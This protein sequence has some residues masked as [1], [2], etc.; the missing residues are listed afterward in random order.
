M[1]VFTFTDEMA[2]FAA[3]C[4]AK[5]SIGETTT[6]F[7][8]K[9]GT[10]RTPQRLRS[11]IKSR[12]FRN[13]R[14]TG[15]IM[16]GVSKIFTPEQTQFFKDNYP[17]MSRKEL[18]AAFNENYGTTFKES[19]IVGFLKANKIKSG[20]TGY[21]SNGQKSWNKGTKGLM[22][23]NGGS[24]KKG[25]AAHNLKPTGSQRVNVE[26]YVE[27]KIDGCKAWKLKQRVVY[28]QHF[29]PLTPA[30]VV[31]FKDGNRLNVDPSN[32]EKITRAEHHY[33]N[34]LGHNTAPPEVKPVI[35]ALA[36]LQA[37]VADRKKA[38]HE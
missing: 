20:R 12:G 16:K 19:Q 10:D 13:G 37:K 11:N 2:D 14:T 35:H 34:Q 27:I 7:N 22:K 36:K 25:Q 4:Y 31:R 30:D 33:L 3:Q 24:F 1:A 5:M 21:Y 9:F 18:T 15:E 6:L 29:G 26:G 38:T 17:N 23:P 8:E 32:L 28:E